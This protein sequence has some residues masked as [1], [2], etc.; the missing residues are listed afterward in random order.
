[1]TKHFPGVWRR[2]KKKKNNIWNWSENLLTIIWINMTKTVGQFTY[3][4]KATTSRKHAHANKR[5]SKGK[6]SS[7]SYSAEA[8]GSYFPWRQ[9]NMAAI[10][11]AAAI[12]AEK[13]PRLHDKSITYGTAGFRTKSVELLLTV[14]LRV[15]FILLLSISLYLRWFGHVVTVRLLYRIKLPD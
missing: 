7:R 14:W 3:S 12:A 6:G 4:P 15:S 11:K 2:I 1:M 9:T 10:E 5:A 13:H 8:I